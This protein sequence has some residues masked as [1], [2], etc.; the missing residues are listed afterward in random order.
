MSEFVVILNDSRVL[1]VE[2]LCKLIYFP[3]AIEIIEEIRIIFLVYWLK[4]TCKGKNLVRSL[5]P[6]V[7]H[8]LIVDVEHLR[9]IVCF[10]E[11]TEIEGLLCFKN[12][13]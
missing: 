12:A 7:I 10:K 4:T 5:F 11:G 1:I 13:W 3:S 9:N 6:E 2:F 8:K